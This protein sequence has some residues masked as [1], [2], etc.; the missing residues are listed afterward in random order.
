M[1]SNQ[2]QTADDAGD[3]D[4]PEPALPAFALKPVA[5]IAVVFAAVQSGLSGRYGFH[6][7]EL[8]FMAA[9]DHPA[10]GY[11]DQPP[12]TPLLARASTE[13]FG[14]SPVG[15]RV[16]A[17][18]AA[19]AALF[20]VALAAREL[21]SGTPGQV[22]A[23][24]FAATSGFVLA[25][26]HMVSTSTFD[27]LAWLAICWVALR[28]LRTGDGRWWPVLGAAIGIGAFN[29]HLVV[30]LVAALLAGVLL[31]GPR[32]VLR[33]RLMPVGVLIAA[34]FALPNVLWQIDHG[35]PQLTVAEGI[36]E[37]D[38]AENRAMFVPQQL[39]FLSPFF[40]PVWIAGLV[41][42]FRDPQVRWARALAVAYPVVCVAVVAMGGK[43]YYALPP[44]LV[45]TAAG[46]DPVLRWM[47][48]SRRSAR[49]VLVA[50]ALA[51]SAVINAVVTLPVL[52]ADALDVPMAVNQEQGEQVG[53]P[54]LADAVAAAW[55]GIPAEQ[56]PRTVIFAGNYGEAGA[57]R[58]YGPE[59]GLP[60]AYSGHMS[61]ADWG[62]PPDSANGP[63]LVV[64]IAGATGQDRFFTGCRPA[65]RVDNGKDLDNEE[66]D[67]EVLVCDGT[68]RPW[69]ALWPDLRRYY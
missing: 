8:Y 6:R 67:A 40:V 41:R 20:L 18:L 49:G 9:G 19:V 24:A 2:S 10:W 47:R 15:L 35:W 55:A 63:V 21:G 44:L 5:A 7:D 50:A 22:L 28:L 69:S 59:R 26:G 1:S 58:Y 42:L 43:S 29:K 33:S 48:S 68:S 32:S 36:A 52:P 14:S 60:K 34:L 54:E 17:I 39:L 12:L 23:T 56:R 64:H 57:L 4:V 66:Q 16:V 13:L 65:A 31:V 46:C 25:S 30:L 11:V 61:F 37:D 45:L 27:L 62:P 53:W 38:G 3:A 51:L